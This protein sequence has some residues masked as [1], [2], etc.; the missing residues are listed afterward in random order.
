MNR[1]ARGSRRMSI[2]PSRTRRF[3]EIAAVAPG[4]TL[5]EVLVA[6]TL[7]SVIGMALASVLLGAQRTQRTSAGWMLAVQLAADGLE[8]LR[9]GRTLA[10]APPGFSRLGSV[11]PTGVAGLQRLEVTVEWDDGALRRYQLSALVQQ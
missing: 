4:F 3:L 11:T 9:A 1:H 7:L 10:S 5:I 8:Q 6:L 2:L